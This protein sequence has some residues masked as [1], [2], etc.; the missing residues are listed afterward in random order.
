MPG[1]SQLEARCYL[2]GS[3]AEARRKPGTSQAEARRTVYGVLVEGHWVG[4]ASGLVPWF[5][6]DG[7]GGTNSQCLLP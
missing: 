7:P 2:G 3:Q 6:L 4:V 5:G 1:G